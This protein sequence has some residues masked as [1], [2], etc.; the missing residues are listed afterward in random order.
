MLSRCIALAAK[1]I[2]APK[3]STMKNS[4]QGTL[5]W[6]RNAERAPQ[7]ADDVPSNDCRPGPET[8]P[9]NDEV[10]DHQSAEPGELADL[11]EEVCADEIRAVVNL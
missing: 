11:I 7:D 9:A 3:I 2:E 5:R 10:S 1:N 6:T 4:G 8:V